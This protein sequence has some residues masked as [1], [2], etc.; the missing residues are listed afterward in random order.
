MTRN[1][2]GRT[3]FYD[4]LR[5]TALVAT[6]AYYRQKYPIAVVAYMVAEGYYKLAR[7]G[8]DSEFLSY[9]LEQHKKGHIRI[10]YGAFRPDVNGKA[11]RL[12]EYDGEELLRQ[13]GY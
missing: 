13:W 2:V 9:L 5:P 12:V 4:A 3:T 10:V 11:G 8:P 7:V 1:N 6:F